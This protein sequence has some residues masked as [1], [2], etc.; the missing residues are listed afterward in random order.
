MPSSLNSGPFLSLRPDHD[1]GRSKVASPK[2]FASLSGTSSP[3]IN[4]N[5]NNYSHTNGHGNLN[6][7]SNGNGHSRSSSHDEFLRLDA[8]QQDL[9]LLHGPRQKYKLEKSQDLPVLQGDREILVQVL[10]I[11]LNPVDWKGAEN[12]TAREAPIFEEKIIY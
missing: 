2:S 6:N 10:A 5:G 4:G 8:P 11:G 3:A 1:C 9:L 12:G 7:T